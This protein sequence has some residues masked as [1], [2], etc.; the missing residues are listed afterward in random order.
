M[1]VVRVA[2]NWLSAHV[3]NILRG[4]GRE[5]HKVHLPIIRN[6][7]EGRGLERRDEFG[8]I[9]DRVMFDGSMSFNGLETEQLPETIRDLYR[10]VAL[11]VARAVVRLNGRGDLNAIQATLAAN[12]TSGR[13]LEELAG[14]ADLISGRDYGNAEGHRIHTGC[15]EFL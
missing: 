15:L 2:V 7:R 9:V 6:R 10:L 11:G 14:L 5:G 12:G 1:A 8:M 13:V 4:D 3:R